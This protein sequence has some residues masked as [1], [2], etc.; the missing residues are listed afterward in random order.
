MVKDYRGSGADAIIITLHPET[1]IEDLVTR[2]VATGTPP[3]G[4][5]VGWVNGFRVVLESGPWVSGAAGAAG[6]AV[7]AG[8]T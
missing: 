8:S 4:N 3:E 5:I 1:I 6:N 7:A 2:S